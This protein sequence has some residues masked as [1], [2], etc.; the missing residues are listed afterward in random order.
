[1]MQVLYVSGASRPMDEQDLDA[2]LTISRFNNERDGIT[3]ML[4]WADGAFIQVLEG[5]DDKVRETMRRISLDPRH[6]HVIPLVEQQA[7]TRAFR[8][9]SMGFK[10]LNMKRGAD[11]HVFETSHAALAGRVSTADGGVLLSMMLAFGRD[12]VA[13]A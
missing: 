10:R 1:M 2:I 9:W 13:A 6:R 7:A 5:E 3:G 11:K 12:F 4:L 8:D